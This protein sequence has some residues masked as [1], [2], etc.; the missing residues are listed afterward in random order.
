M[1][2]TLAT[3]RRPATVSRPRFGMGWP[4]A[5]LRL[6]GRWCERRRQRRD[7]SDLDDRLLDDIGI[8]RRQAD[9]ECRKPF[10]R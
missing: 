1:P 3:A 6:M 10:W 5:V 9:E 4:L 8:T 7:L 2:T